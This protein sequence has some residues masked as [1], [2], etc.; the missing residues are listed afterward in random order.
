M[1]N[2]SALKGVTGDILVYFGQYHKINFRYVDI[3]LKFCS[4]FHSLDMIY[5]CFM[6]K[7]P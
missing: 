7:L 4:I 6:E 2:I 5:P 1:I 3:F